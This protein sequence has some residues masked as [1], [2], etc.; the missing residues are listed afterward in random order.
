[1]AELWIDA[2]NGSDSA[3]GEKDDPLATIIEALARTVG[4]GSVTFHVSLGQYTVP[5]EGGKRV[6]VSNEIFPRLNRPPVNL[7][8]MTDPR[9]KD[10][11][12]AAIY[13]N[14]IKDPSTVRYEEYE[15]ITEPVGD[16]KGLSRVTATVWIHKGYGYKITERR[17][18]RDLASSKAWCAETGRE[19]VMEKL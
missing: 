4:D 8:P 1:M 14:I 9:F 6:E 16:A 18:Y 19:I 17:N 3:K 12:E 10:Q 2:E 13:H 15:K 7:N 5:V 11:Y